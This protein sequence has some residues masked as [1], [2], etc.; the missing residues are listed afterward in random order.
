[1]TK[2]RTETSIVTETVIEKET[3]DVTGTATGTVTATEIGTAT[4]ATLVR[5]LP[6]YPLFFSSLTTRLPRV[7]LQS[8][9]DA[10]VVAI[11][12]SLKT[13]SGATATYVFLGL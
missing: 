1:M 2:K 3:P 12:G 7:S 13:V 6:L 9:A 4:D 8:E 11:I 10:V 5:R